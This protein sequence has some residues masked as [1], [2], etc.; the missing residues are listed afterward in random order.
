MFYHKKP[1][2][3]EAFIYE[4]NSFNCY[5]EDDYIIPEW[6]INAY[7][8]GI[9]SFKYTEN[10]LKAIIKTFKGNMVVN[11]GDYIVKDINGELYSC[12]PDIFEKIYQP[13]WKD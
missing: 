12:K 11:V 6:A 1:I 2:I 3:I 10:E 8:N 7:K 4:G 13:I 9:I 5:D